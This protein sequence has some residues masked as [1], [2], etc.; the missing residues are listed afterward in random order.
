MLDELSLLTNIFLELKDRNTKFFFLPRK[1]EQFS[2]PCISFLMS[3]H[4]DITFP[5]VVYSAKFIEREKWLV[6]GGSDGYI[7]VYSYESY[8]TM[9]EVECFKAHDGYHITS[10][11]VEP[12]HSLVLSTSADHMIKLWTWEKGWECIQTFLGHYNKVTQVMF[13]PRDSNR[14]V[15]ASLDRTVKVLLYMVL[16]SNPCSVR[17][18]S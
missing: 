13:D 9:E 14:F 15:S 7:Y 1:Q 10:L 16:Q 12:T 8:D 17:S 18:E 4:S 5:T 3:S 11:A 2:V 6:V